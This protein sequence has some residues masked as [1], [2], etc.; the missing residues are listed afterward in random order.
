MNASIPYCRI[1]VLFYL[2]S[3]VAGVGQVTASSQTTQQVS[4]SPA[5][6]Q[7]SQNQA[8]LQAFQQEQLALARQERAL[9]AGGATPQQLEAWHQQNAAQFA[10]QQQRAQALATASAL[11]MRRTNRQPNIPADAS[12]T[13]KDFLTTQAAL[14][15]AR[16]QIHNQLVQQ[17]TASGQSLTLAQ[18]GKM[19]QRANQLFQ[20]QNAALLTLQTQR[21]QALANTAAQT[22]RPLPKPLVIPPNATPQMAAFLTTRYQIRRELVQMRN[23]YVTATPAVRE[24][25]LRQ[26]LKQNASLFAQLQQQEQSLS[27]AN[28]TTPN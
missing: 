14:A 8:T 1:G 7:V 17:A 5:T 20:Q 16:A 23:Q 10:A 25:A 4:S 15:N 13:L 2:V 28:T 12:P 19:E 6:E 24:A 27:Q 11:Q 21:S 18:I 26:W 3:T 22:V 9:E